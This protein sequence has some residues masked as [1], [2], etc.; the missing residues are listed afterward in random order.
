[1]EIGH[2]ETPGRGLPV[3]TAF[4]STNAFCGVVHCDRG[5]HRAAGNT[6]LFLGIWEE[7]NNPQFNS[8]EFEGISAEAGR[9]SFYLSAKRWIAATGRRGGTFAHRDLAFEFGSWLSPEFKLYLITQFQRLKGDESQRLSEAWDLTRTLSRLNYKA[10][11]ATIKEKLVPL[12]VTPD[13]AVSIYRSEADLLNVALFGQTAEEW[14]E[15]HPE[16]AGTMRDYAS[17]E[18]LLV[19]S[20]LENLNA[21]FIQLELPP[22]ERLRRL[23]GIAIRQMSALAARD[24]PRRIEQRETAGE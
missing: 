3:A 16:L 12:S 19:L 7:L 1:M 13:Q 23:N 10:L 18:Q 21:E 5:F 6:I 22:E 14:R 11:S 2:G 20:G 9:S 4:A 24:V 8:L 15:A 17:I